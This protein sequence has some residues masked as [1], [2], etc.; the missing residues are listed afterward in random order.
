M[1]ESV[2]PQTEI[3]DAERVAI[4]R[5]LAEREHRTPFLRLCDSHE[6]LRSR[7]E[8][9]EARAVALREF[10]VDALVS[11]GLLTDPA[12]DVALPAALDRV[13]KAD[14]WKQ[15]WE[16]ATGHLIEA[17]SETAAAEARVVALTRALAEIVGAY[18]E[19]RALAWVGSNSMADD[20][21]VRAFTA[22]I[23]NARALA[24]VRDGTPEESQR[25]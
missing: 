14:D 11:R 20:A 4:F 17:Q 12:I 23:H 10:I 2:R 24:A 16:V 19:V 25:A 13:R 3:L 8:E 21:T 6:A 15:R 9:A 22:V 7:V 1:S 5:S 18:E